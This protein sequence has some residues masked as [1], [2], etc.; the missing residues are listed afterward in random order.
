MNRLRVLAVGGGAG[1]GS[2][3]AG[4]GASGFVKNAEFAVESGVTIAITVGGGGAGSTF[5]QND[6]SQNA[7]PGARSFFGLFLSA[8]GGGTTKC[9][10]LSVPAALVEDRA[11]RAPVGVA[12]GVQEGPTGICPP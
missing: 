7:K 1:G 3:N 8:D 5:K 12:L 11:V 2:G 6:P 4:G 9:I 10:T